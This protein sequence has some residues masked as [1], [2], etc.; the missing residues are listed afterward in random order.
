MLGILLEE[1]YKNNIGSKRRLS[2][3]LKEVVKKEIVK[4]LDA[5]IIHHISDS[6]C[7]SPIQYVSKKV[8]MTIVINEKYE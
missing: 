1:D 6:V 2:P 4:W 5:G 8:N 7:V 3:I